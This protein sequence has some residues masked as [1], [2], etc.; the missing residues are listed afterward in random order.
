[1]LDRS[2]RR[3]P[4]PR[5]PAPHPHRQLARASSVTTPWGI[6]KIVIIYAP[7]ACSRRSLIFTLGNK[8]QLRPHRRAEPR[9]DR[10]R[11]HRGLDRHGDD[12]GARPQVHAAADLAVLLHLLLQHLRDHPGHSRCRP[13]P[14][15][16]CRCSW[17][18][19]PTSLYHGAGFREH[20]PSATSSTPVAPRAC[21]RRST[22]LVTPDRVH[23]RSSWCRRSRTRVRLFA[24]LL[25][26]AHPPRH[27]RQCSRAPCRRPS[28][29][30]S[31]CR[32][33]SPPSIAF[34]AFELLVELPAGL[35]VHAAHRRVHRQ[36]ISHEH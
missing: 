35:R 33:P 9:R 30:R 20:R 24:N 6:N 8:K 28:R 21:R 36:A 23:H 1:M 17:R 31:S 13:P 5:V 29:R 16:P 10:R 18:C 27:V 3:D 34:T 32:C 7:R 11:V 12:R 15:S 14:A 4:G 26:G 25:A 22:C 19:S 2:R